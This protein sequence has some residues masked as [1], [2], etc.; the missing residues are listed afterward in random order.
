[1][2]QDRDAVCM[3]SRG[4]FQCGSAARYHVAV[5]SATDQRVT[6]VNV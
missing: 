2:V 1:M 6:V 3:L 4:S 5:I